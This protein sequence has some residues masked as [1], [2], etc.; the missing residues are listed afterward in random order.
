[1]SYFE[2]AQAAKSMDEETR[3]AMAL[4]L[5]RIYEAD[6]TQNNGLVTG[7]ANLCA[8]FA[9]EARHVLTAAGVLKEDPHADNKGFDVSLLSRFD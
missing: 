8:A 5:L 4:C 1:M 9:T 3:A 7:E 2:M 6:R